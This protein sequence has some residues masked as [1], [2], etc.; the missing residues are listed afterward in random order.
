MVPFI[1]KTLIAKRPLRVDETPEAWSRDA[2][3]RPP[4]QPVN[5]GYQSNVDQQQPS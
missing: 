3:I 5:T 2:I 1:P 4:L